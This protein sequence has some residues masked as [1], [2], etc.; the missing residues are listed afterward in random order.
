MGAR[1]FFGFWK[2]NDVCN[3]SLPFIFYQNA[4]KMCATCW[5]NMK[6]KLKLQMLF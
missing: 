6:V 2:Q 3:L 5:Q 1:A 4:E